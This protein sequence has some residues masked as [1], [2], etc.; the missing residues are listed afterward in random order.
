MVNVIMIFLLVFSVFMIF[1]NHKKSKENILLEDKNK[2]LMMEISKISSDNK[3]IT[4]E[5]LT[6]KE[7]WV[8]LERQAS[9]VMSKMGKPSVNL[10]Y[11]DLLNSEKVTNNV[12]YDVD[13]ILDEI[14]EKG[15]E[16]V[17]KDKIDFLIK[18]SK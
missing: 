1:I 15:R 3:K 11:A 2:K 10:D 6:L 16:N 17:S 18:N 14:R 4:L 12:N 5:Y 13:D 7:M 9:E 8:R